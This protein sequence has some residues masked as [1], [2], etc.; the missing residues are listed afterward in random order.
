MTEK[1]TPGP[2]EID[3][4]GGI[5]ARINGGNRLVAQVVPTPVNDNRDFYDRLVIASA[6]EL[7]AALKMWLEIHDLPAGFEGKYGKEL[8]SVIAAQQRKIDAAAST[9]RAAIKK[10]TGE[11]Q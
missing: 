9:A 5:T 2:W 4:K 3:V 6:P 10:S 7:L 1:H 8:D 11:Q